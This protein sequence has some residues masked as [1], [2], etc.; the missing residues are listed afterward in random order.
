M[1]A[2]FVPI[3]FFSKSFKGV[4]KGSSKVFQRVFKA[5]VSFLLKIAI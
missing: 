3:Y 4:L 2:G 5:P 1:P